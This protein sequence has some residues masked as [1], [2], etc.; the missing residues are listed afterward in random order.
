MTHWTLAYLRHRSGLTQAGGSTCARDWWDCSTIA[1]IRSFSAFAAA[2]FS[3]SAYLLK[4]ASAFCAVYMALP[5][6]GC[7]IPLCWLAWLCC[8]LVCTA[9]ASCLTV[10]CSTLAN[11]A[12]LRALRC[13]LVPGCMTADCA[14]LGTG[15]SVLLFCIAA[16]SVC[17][18]PPGL[19]KLWLLLQL[20][21]CL[22][23]W[24]RQASS[25]VLAVL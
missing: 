14:S 11:S 3:F 8:S 10:C 22:L 23:V 18:W 21:S 1:L 19:Q 15:C 2:A 13:C 25:G 16:G 20:I 5:C 9:A 4:A 7:A 6:S 12:A 24:Q 17:H